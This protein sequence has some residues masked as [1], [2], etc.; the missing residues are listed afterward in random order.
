M[1]K[2]QEQILNDR[3]KEAIDTVVYVMNVDGEHHKT[4]ALD[5]MVQVLANEDYDKVVENFKADTG[6]D[7]EQGIEP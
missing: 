1:E 5:R 6:R 7:W 4:W 3:I 2:T